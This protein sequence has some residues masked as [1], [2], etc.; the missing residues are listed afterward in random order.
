[1]SEVFEKNLQKRADKQ[2]A[3][4]MREIG[5]SVQGVLHKNGILNGNITFSLSYSS[6]HDSYSDNPRYG[7]IRPIVKIN[8]EPREAIRKHFEEKCLTEFEEAL[9]NFAW[10]VEQQ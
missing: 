10:A 9:K 8:D 2:Y 3:D 5:E 6:Y 1:M 4:M 7:R